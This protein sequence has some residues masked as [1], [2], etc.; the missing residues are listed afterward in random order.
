MLLWEKLDG[1]WGRYREQDSPEKQKVGILLHQ[2]PVMAGADVDRRWERPFM[3]QGWRLRMAARHGAKL[4]K[5]C[6]RMGLPFLTSS[7]LLGRAAIGCGRVSSSTN[8]SK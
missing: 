3:A 2:E 5:A 6:V 8:H 7:P 4:G 1:G